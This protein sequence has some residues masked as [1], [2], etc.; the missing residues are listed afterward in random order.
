MA[1][2]K[3]AKRTP[4]SQALIIATGLELVVESGVENVS[5]RHLAQ[6]LNVTPMALYRHFDNKQELLAAMLDEFIQQADVLPNSKQH[7]Q[8]PW[9]LWLHHV[10]SRMYRAL[11]EQPSWLPLLGQLQLQHSGLTVLNACLQKLTE[12]GF[13]NEQAVRAFFAMLQVLFG[14]AITQQQL[15]SSMALAE[16]AIAGDN[17]NYVADAAEALA[18][19]SMV[20]QIDLGMDLLILGLKQQVG[21]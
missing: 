18:E 4:L 10:A 11:V 19:T 16:K 9:D 12:V 14:A 13:S 8:L 20:Q 7:V 15:A 21:S 2:A 1:N 6:K 3:S 5:F 17:Y